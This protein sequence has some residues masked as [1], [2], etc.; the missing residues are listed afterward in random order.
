MRERFTAGR[1]VYFIE[2][3]SLLRV[4]FRVSWCHCTSRVAIWFVY[5]SGTRIVVYTLQ[6]L[7]ATLQRCRE[8]R[9]QMDEDDDY[10]SC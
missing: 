6:R 8:P 2:K 9:R 4:N 5:Q 3:G 10:V 7:L 1:R